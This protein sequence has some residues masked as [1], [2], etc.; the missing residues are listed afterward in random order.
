MFKNRNFKPG[1]RCGQ[2]TPVFLKLILCGSSV[3][4]CVCLCVC[5]PQR[6]FI[7][8]GMIW[9]SYDYLNKF[10]SCYMA[11]IAIIVY[12]RGLGIDTRHRHQPTMSYVVL[13]KALIYCNS[14]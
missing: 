1:A 3:C 6:L 2:R 8:S 13:Y 5:P 9:T 4:V 7:T 10:Y 11:T 14:R 12:G